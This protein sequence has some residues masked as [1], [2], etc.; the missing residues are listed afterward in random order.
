[1]ESEAN[2]PVVRRLRC[3]VAELVA[4][5]DDASAEVSA[6]LD[7]DTGEVI[8]VTPDARMELDGIYPELPEEPMDEETRTAAFAAV[9]ERQGTPEWMQEVVRE[10]D[11]IER[12]FG[13]RF[14]ALPQHDSR[15]AYADME[16][17]IET[18]N[19]PQLEER[20]W[21]AIRGRGAFRRFKNELID[22][23]AEITRWFGFKDARMRARVLQWLADEGIEPIE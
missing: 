23:P 4:A 5:F 16:A 22:D 6:Y 7:L 10:A 15:E 8:R 11:V 20:L 2:L 3:N 13:T 1:M 9:F 17:F 19:S 18:V 12:D 21:V 14:L